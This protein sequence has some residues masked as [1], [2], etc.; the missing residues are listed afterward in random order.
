LPAFEKGPMRMHKHETFSS[1][2]LRRCR[3]TRLASRLR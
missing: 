3:C 1:V 2:V